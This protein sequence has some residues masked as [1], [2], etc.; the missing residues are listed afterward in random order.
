MLVH[1]Y[2]VAPTERLSRRSEPFH[3]LALHIPLPP[4]LPF[5]FFIAAPA[6]QVDE[7]DSETTTTNGFVYAGS[8]ADGF[9][10]VTGDLDQLSNNV[11]C[12]QFADEAMSTVLSTAIADGVSAGNRQA[13]SGTCFTAWSGKCF[14]TLICKHVLHAQ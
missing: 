6:N 9:A 11:Y 3:Y 1:A 10:T 13:W 4:S 14:T 2:R 7:S 8:S 12:D 5:F